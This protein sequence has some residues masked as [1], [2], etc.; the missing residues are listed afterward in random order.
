M[1]SDLTVALDFLLI[2]FFYTGKS[3]VAATKDTLSSGRKSEKAETGQPAGIIGPGMRPHP[4]KGGWIIT[5]YLTYDW[6]VN[7]L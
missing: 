7:S 6:C 5:D 1:H 2:Y 3:E 4:L